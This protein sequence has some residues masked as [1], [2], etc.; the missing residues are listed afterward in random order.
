MDNKIPKKRGRLP[1][2]KEERCHPND[3]VL[4]TLCNIYYI[5]GNV[6]KHK[7]TRAHKR[8]Q[9][10]SN[11]IKI[12]IEGENTQPKVISFNKFKE[13]LSLKEVHKIINK[14]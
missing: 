10:R 6:S 14:K 1:K 2:P 13:Y 4:C 7:Q 11:M 5:R 8:L 9:E 12:I 3:R